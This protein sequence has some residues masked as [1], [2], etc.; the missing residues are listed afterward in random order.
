MK[1]KWIERERE[2]PCMCVIFD[3]AHESSRVTQTAFRDACVVIKTASEASEA[4][5]N[6]L[7]FESSRPETSHTQHNF[8]LESVCSSVMQHNYLHAHY[9]SN[10]DPFGDWIPESLILVLNASFSSQTQQS[11]SRLS[12]IIKWWRNV[13]RDPFNDW[14]IIYSWN[15][16]GN[17]SKVI[18]SIFMA[19]F[20]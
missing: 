20:N 19:E 12:L 7:N 1:V 6:S 17:E 10:A 18:C 4:S 8:D 3:A 5:E 9:Y 16:F 15:P 11:Y 2:L 13:V 14:R